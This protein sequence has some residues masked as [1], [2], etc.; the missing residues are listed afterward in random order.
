MIAASATDNGPPPSLV[1]DA[2]SVVR[3][4]E[5]IKGEIKDV[6]GTPVWGGSGG[7]LSK[8]WTIS[9]LSRAII[10]EADPI[11]FRF[12]SLSLLLRR[13]RRMKKTR[14]HEAAMARKPKTTMT[15]IAQ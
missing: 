15:A 9:W 12:D 10:G 3:F 14:M 8:V 6:D 11:E 4:P 7:L 1:V 5:G 2:A 13:R